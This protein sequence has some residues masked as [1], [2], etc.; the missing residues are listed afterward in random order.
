MATPLALQLYTVRQALTADRAAAIARVAAMG[1]KA[2]EP[3]AIGSPDKDPAERL[4]DART[5][6]RLCDEHG[7]TVC[8]VHGF[9]GAD[10]AA[11]AVYEELD[12]LGTNRLIA[13]S[14]G[15]VPGVN[16][17][18]LAT[19]DGVKKLADGLNAGA[20]R[21]A[22]HGIS[23]GYHNH[24]FEWRPVE[25]GT[26]AYD[27]LVESLE[28]S[29]FLELDIYWAYTG[30]QDPATVV[31]KYADRVQLLHVKDGPGVRGELQT[32]IGTGRV[33]NVAACRAGT[34]VAWHIAELDDTA[35]DPFEVARDGA[36]WL[37]EQGVS[38]WE[39]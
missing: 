32:A 7:L 12:A 20:A 39:N 35:G 30:G 10:S 11:D 22:E 36:A 37:V 14:P 8:G 9:V 15:A 13:S 4:A 21:A 28:P 18:A 34:N 17:D 27:V 1:F 16:R 24:D 6:R 5:L 3:Y 31:R 38:R 19:R 25:D 26:P 23:V 29:V 33:D 2:V